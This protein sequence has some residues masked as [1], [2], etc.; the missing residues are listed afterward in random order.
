VL[1]RQTAPVIGANGSPYSPPGEWQI[2]LS[3]RDLR[4]TDHYSQAVEQIQ[5]QT[6][7]TNVVNIQNSVDLTV[8]YQKS[9]RLGFT[10]GVPFLSASWSIPTPTGPTPGPRAQQDTRG[11][12]DIS[13]AARYWVLN[14]RSHL[15]GNI[16]IGLGVKAPTGTY[17]AQDMY[18]DSTGKNDQLRYVDQSIQPG[19]GGWGITTE[20]QAFHTIKRAMIFASG[21][22]L[23]NPRNTNGTPSLTVARLAPGA[24]PAASNYNKLVNSV[25]DQYLVRTGGSLGLGRGLAASF[26]WRVEG[27][28]RYDLLGRSDGFRRPGLEMFVEPGISYSTGRGTLSFNVPIGFYRDRKLD[29]YTNLAG[30]ATFPNHIALGSYS[31]RF[32]GHRPFQR[33]PVPALPDDSAATPELAAAF[34]ATPVALPLPAR[35]QAAALFD[36]SGMTCDHCVDVVREA[37]HR[38]NGVQS[39]EVNLTQQQASVVYDP[40]K[41]DVR[42]LVEAVR[43]SK[44][45]NAYDAQAVSAR[46]T[47]TIT[48][49]TCELCVESV[50]SALLAAKGVTEATV[51]L[52]P[53]EAVV[54]YDPSKTKVAD[55]VGA[56]KKAKGMNRY[57]ADVQKP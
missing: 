20:I 7:G 23:I 45:M 37:L 19:D 33:T 26:A 34:K 9:E 5:R 35:G 17:N 16:G 6:L 41:T 43:T 25:P 49:M 8:G 21:N 29:P 13:A 32:G 57:S 56:V 31:V 10:V 2:N 4:S 55:L 48:G 3:T 30:D 40:A 53:A 51:T 24:V 11:I 22:Y 42:E 47:L 12:G 50:R 14:T 36:I 39:A 18:P 46:V 54:T 27:M 44:G 15:K 38:V 28:P 1:I 52:Q